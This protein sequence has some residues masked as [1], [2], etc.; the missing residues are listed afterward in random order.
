[1]NR[2]TFPPHLRYPARVQLK[3]VTLIG[4]GL[5]G[6]SLGLALKQRGL[7]RRVV[8][9]VRREA[10]VAECAK[11]GVVDH[12][13]LDLSEAVQDANL[14]VFCTPLAQMRTLAMQM[15]GQLRPGVLV[16]DVGSVKTSVIRELAP[17]LKR[18]GAVFIGSHPM[19]GSEKTG[20]LAARADLFEKAV[21]I[22][23]PTPQTPP[24]AVRRLRALWKAVGARVLE[25]SPAQHD[26][27]VSR[28]SHLPH[29]AA[30]QLATLV[31]DPRSP[32]ELA[33]L[34]ATGFRDTTRIASGSPEMWRDIV[35]ANR[36]ALGKSLRAYVRALENL[37]RLI[38]RGD[39]AALEKFFNTAK[40][41]RDAW[42]EQLASRSQE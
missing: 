15:S 36:E 11:A 5:L 18:A 7:A 33:Q 20:P 23:T 34:C 37:G 35:S 16:T 29:L 22:V 8:G 28:S 26:E 14:I 42:C 30:A 3:Q 41:R 2:S 25:L 6:G 1:M 32:K 17:V 12:A 40:Q 27:L 31:L 13:T 38:E 9:Y 10:S 21:C 4:V 24:G 39:S 19:A